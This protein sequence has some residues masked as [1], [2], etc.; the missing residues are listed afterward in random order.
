MQVYFP[1]YQEM[2]AQVSEQ[3]AQARS[4]PMGMGMGLGQYADLWCHEY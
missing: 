2:M 1:K 3:E 4:D